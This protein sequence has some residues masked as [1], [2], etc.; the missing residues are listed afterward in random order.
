ML[1]VWSW[2]SISAPDVTLL[3]LRIC[4][5]A[6]T[7]YVQG[8]V[9]PFLPSLALSCWWT[10]Q[11]TLAPCRAAA[12]GALLQ[13]RFLAARLEPISWIIYIYFLKSNVFLGGFSCLLC[14]LFCYLL[15]CHVS[16][17]R[18]YQ[19]D[20]SPTNYDEVE[21]SFGEVQSLCE[22]TVPVCQDG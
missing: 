2:C 21:I 1:I 7:T 3:L 4:C 16:D 10:S 11:T 13:K 15:S 22:G 9:R 5:A 19:F 12:S 8:G 6:A 18:V 17:W 20:W 14:L